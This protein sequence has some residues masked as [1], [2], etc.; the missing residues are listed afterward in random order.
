[1]LPCYNLG[2]RASS[3]TSQMCRRLCVTAACGVMLA[4]ALYVPARPAMAQPAGGAYL[5]G[6]EPWTESDCAGDVPV[7][8]GSD[9]AAQSDIYSAVTLAGALGTDCIVLAGPRGSDMAPVQQGRLDA[10]AT[11]GWIVGGTTA[12]PVGKTAGRAM[13]RLAG[14]DRWATAHLAGSHARTAGDPAATAAPVPRTPTAAPDDVQRP[15]LHLGGAGPWIAS[16]CAGDVPV[17]VGSDAAAQSDIYSAVTLAGALGTD[18]IVL[19]GPRGSDMAPVQQGRLDAAATGGWIVGGTTAV[20]VGKTAG[21]AMTRLAGDDRWATAHLVGR[22]ASGDVTVGTSTADEAVSTSP[23]YT[24]LSASSNFTCGV[25]TSGEVD[26]WGLGTLG[27]FDRHFGYHLKGWSDV[28]H[29]EPDGD[30]SM[31]STAPKHA[32]A[33][34]KSGAAVC[35]GNWLHGGFQIGTTYDSAQLQPAAHDNMFTE[36]AAGGD[37]TC[38]LRPSGE[39]RCWGTQTQMDSKGIRDGRFSTIVA[40][41]TLVCG[42]RL[43]AKPSAGSE[44]ECW[45]GDANA[46]HRSPPPGKFTELSLGGST[47]CGL[48]PTGAVVCWGDWDLNEVEGLDG[49]PSPPEGKFIT[50]DVGDDHGCGIRTSGETVC[51]GSDAYGKA[52]PPDEKLSAIAAGLRHTCGLRLSGEAVCW[53]AREILPLPEGEFS[54]VAVGRGGSHACGLRVSGRVTCWGSISPRAVPDGTFV[55]VTANGYWSC[56]LRKSGQMICWGDDPTR[57]WHPFTKSIFEQSAFS[58]IAISTYWGCGI[59]NDGTGKVTCGG[60][61]APWQQPPSGAFVSVEII[62]DSFACGLRT[63]GEVA[64]WWLNRVSKNEEDSIPMPSG[65]FSQFS[66][67]GPGY[68]GLRP[69]GEFECWE[70]PSL[71]PRFV[72]PVQPEGKFVDFV[73]VATNVVN[74]FCGL[75]PAGEIECWHALDQHPGNRRALMWPSGTFVTL[76]GT[77]PGS[78]ILCGRRT[79]GAHYC[80]D[81]HGEHIGGYLSALTQTPQ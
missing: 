43:S 4:A 23:R 31:V 20:P 25:R 49:V 18:C 78:R 58:D 81:T 56:G 54:A 75:R 16:D 57:H 15:G 2:V 63:S 60:Q 33:L 32:C 48:R 41:G 30:F 70:D 35:W 40:G 77:K 76:E 73:G 39:V 5:T 74:I 62:N 1:M 52:S 11:G 22:R 27:E 79:S 17:V 66:A 68:C 45:G 46:H 24:S 13:T 14:D 53:G 44:A 59:H 28:V 71:D 42:L 69:T 37:F 47:G 55:A 26:C 65:I 9:A 36:I 10:A 8:V 51:W 61:W 3:C 34:R 72:P 38:G 67:T 29:S 50:L 7:V 6:S 80:W 19:A 21:R 12:V 64:C